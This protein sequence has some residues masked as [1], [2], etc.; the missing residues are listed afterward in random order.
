MMPRY[1]IARRR[2]FGDYTALPYPPRGGCS[3][4]PAGGG[5]ASIIGKAGGTVLAIAPLTGPAAPFVAL[6]G[7]ITSL[8][9][10]LFGGHAKKVAQESQILCAAVPAAN[11]TLQ[12]IYQAVQSGQISA[13]DGS[14][15]LD[16]LATSFANAVAPIAKGTY[17]GQV[18]AGGKITGG[19]SSCNGACLYQGWLAQAIQQAKSDF[20]RM[21]I[22]LPASLPSLPASLP[23]L[24]ASLPAAFSQLTQTGNNGTI[25]MIVLLGGLGLAMLSD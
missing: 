3:G 11:S 21:S 16:Q 18:D 17:T 9:S 14:A 15:A 5:T 13:A 25:W 22:S 1:A 12:Q 7:A 10:S 20:S 8:F 23:S 2:R 24:P 19:S 6:A 4:Q